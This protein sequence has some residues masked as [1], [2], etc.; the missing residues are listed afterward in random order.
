MHLVCYYLY[1]LYDTFV[2][3]DV[4]RECI[5]HVVLNNCCPVGIYG[6]VTIKESLEACC[7]GELKQE[8]VDKAMEKIVIDDSEATVIHPL[9]KSDRELII[10]EKKDNNSDEATPTTYTANV[11]WND[12]TQKWKETTSGWS[13]TVGAGAEKYTKGHGSFEYHQGKTE[14]DIKTTSFEVT[15]PFKHS[16]DMEPHSSSEVTVVKVETEYTADIKK[17]RLKFPHDTK[18]KV[19]PVLG[20]AG[21]KTLSKI[22]EKKFTVLYKRDK[23]DNAIVELDAKFK[24]M[25]ITTEVAVYPLPP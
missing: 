22:L 9:S 14:R 6:F 10:R 15:M 3:D 20:P 25:H 5:F 17:L 2:R 13:V 4:Y 1:R 16:F 12:T 11:T 21:K 18:L 23:D 19:R 8:Y 24:A 7:G